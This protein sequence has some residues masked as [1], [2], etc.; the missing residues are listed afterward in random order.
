MGDDMLQD[1]PIVVLTVVVVCGGGGCD[2]M[3]GPN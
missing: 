1:V 3:D 2:D